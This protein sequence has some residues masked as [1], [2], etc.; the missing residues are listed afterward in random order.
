M[1]AYT[2]QAESAEGLN[3]APRMEPINKTKKTSNH[4]RVGES[5]ISISYPGKDM[6]K[7]PKHAS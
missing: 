3:S 6:S 2:G 7:K 1:N 4:Q 5:R